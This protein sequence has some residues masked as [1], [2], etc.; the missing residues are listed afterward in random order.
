MHVVGVNK[1]LSKNVAAAGIRP[2]DTPS[3]QS[4]SELALD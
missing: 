4:M 3:S 2:F 1:C